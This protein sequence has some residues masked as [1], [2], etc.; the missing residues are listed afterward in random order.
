MCLYFN[1]DKTGCYNST[2]KQ[3][4]LTK[5]DHKLCNKVKCVFIIISIHSSDE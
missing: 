3:A 2:R 4:I 5:R 1:N